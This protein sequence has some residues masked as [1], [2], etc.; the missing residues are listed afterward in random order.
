MLTGLDPRTSFPIL[1]ADAGTPF[2]GGRL[3]VLVAFPTPDTGVALWDVATWDA[4]DLFA[5]LTGWVDVSCWTRSVDVTRG[6][7]PYVD[8][9]DA[10]VGRI[11]LDNRDGR[12]SPWNRG[13]PYAVGG[14][15]TIAPGLPVAVWFATVDDADRWDAADPWDTA[16]PWDGTLTWWPLCAGVVESWG[17]SWP[18][19]VDDEVAVE[20]ADPFRDLAAVEWNPG[21]LADAGQVA[22]DRIAQLLDRAGCRWPTRIDPG[23]AALEASTYAGTALDLVRLAALSDGGAFYALGDGTLAFDDANRPARPVVAT[24]TD[25]SAPGIPYVDPGPVV[26]CDDYGLTNDVIVSNGAG[27]VSTA[28]DTA[29]QS[30]HGRRTYRRDALEYAAQ[31]HGDA[32]AARLVDARAWD[33]CRVAGVA[34]DTRTAPTVASFAAALELRD[35]VRVVRAFA[36][37][38]LDAELEVLGIAHAITPDAWTCALTTTPYIARTPL[39]PTGVDGWDRARWDAGQWTQE[40]A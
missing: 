16:D 39:P 7:S 38:T 17:E 8:T 23:V 3:A 9:Y 20:F 19:V 2:A 22:G 28:T 6:R 21:P 36:G 14:V 26:A 35:R 10:G 37:D 33:S 32:L 24:L 15:S 30:V 1:D 12:F 11:V 29:S 25:C 4:G 34:V 18:G 27:L 13:G 31:A 5:G 40:V